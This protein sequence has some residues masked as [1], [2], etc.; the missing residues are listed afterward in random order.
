MSTTAGLSQWFADNVDNNANHYSFTWSGSSDEAELVYQSRGLSAFQQH[1]IDKVA[2]PLPDGPLEERVLEAAQA[3]IP[4]G[5]L[6]LLIMGIAYTIP[7][8]VLVQTI[9]TLP[10]MIRLMSAS[11]ETVPE[12]LIHAAR[13]LGAGPAGIV[14]HIILPLC[15]PGLMAGGL[16]SFVGSFEEFDKTFIAG[17]T[18]IQT[19]PI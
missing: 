18:F 13:S 2:Q 1:E 5:L 19:L 10:L 17:A 4:P 12:E 14:T 7:G 3:A 15:I 11:F 6:A 16:L 8:V 9:G